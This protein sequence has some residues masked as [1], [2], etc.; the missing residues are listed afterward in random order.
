MIKANIADAKRAQLSKHK[1]YSKVLNELLAEKKV[2]IPIP[3]N[4][5]AALH[6][7]IHDVPFGNLNIH[8]DVYSDMVS[9]EPETW[10]IPTL[11]TAAQLIL[12]KWKPCENL[13]QYLD[14]IKPIVSIVNDIYRIINETNEETLTKLNTRELLA[15]RM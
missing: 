13:G 4:F 14:G 10:D 7:S 2:S 5:R 15:G 8:I 12:T 1:D 11:E 6:N 3:D 9:T